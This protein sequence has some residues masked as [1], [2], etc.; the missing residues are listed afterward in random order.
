MYHKTTLPYFDL[1]VLVENQLGL[2][3]L[4]TS[5]AVTIVHSND[6]W[7][8][9]CVIRSRAVGYKQPGKMGQHIFL[10]KIFWGMEKGE[11]E[12]TAERAA[13]SSWQWQKVMMIQVWTKL[14]RSERMTN[15]SIAK[16]GNKKSQMPNVSTLK[17]GE[18]WT[19]KVKVKVIQYLVILS[20]LF[21]DL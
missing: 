17:T 7:Y 18:P 4:R 9:S 11:L 16:H 14:E 1:E 2:L 21:D 12:W 15:K 19:I 6:T 10:K 20:Y 8:V 3:P 5:T 13:R